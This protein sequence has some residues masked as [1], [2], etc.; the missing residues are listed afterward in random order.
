M[1]L[2]EIVPEIVIV[3]RDVRFAD[4]SLQILILRE[5]HLAAHVHTHPVRRDFLYR[6]ILKLFLYTQTLG[7]VQ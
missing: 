6:P 4:E 3:S 1:I 7:P 2:Q 5:V